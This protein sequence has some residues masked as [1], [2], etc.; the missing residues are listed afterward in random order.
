MLLGSN[1]MPCMR[2]TEESEKLKKSNDTHQIRMKVLVQ[3]SWRITLKRLKFQ[4][5]KARKRRLSNLLKTPFRSTKKK[6]PKARFQ[7]SSAKREASQR[8]MTVLLK[9]P[10]QSKWLS[11][12]SLRLAKEEDIIE[13]DFHRYFR[14]W[15]YLIN[16][17]NC[18]TCYNEPLDIFSPALLYQTFEIEIYSCFL[19]TRIKSLEQGEQ[20]YRL[21]WCSSIFRR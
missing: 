13:N 16:I 14:Y 17:D 11:S 8:L 3:E 18:S 2:N 10:C 6:V 4:E 1:I 21:D 19:K 7:S 5:M 12:N 15:W 20:I 9:K